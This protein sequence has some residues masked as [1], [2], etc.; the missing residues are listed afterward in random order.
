MHAPPIK[1]LITIH[2]LWRKNVALCE[3]IFLNLTFYSPKT[4]NIV[5]KIIGL[6]LYLCI[7]MKLK[8]DYKKLA[9]RAKL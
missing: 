6:I 2:P 4:C 3:S 9:I 8:P 5:E 1:V 7:F